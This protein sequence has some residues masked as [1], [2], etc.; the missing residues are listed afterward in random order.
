MKVLVTGRC[1]VF[2]DRMWPSALAAE[3]MTSWAARLGCCATAVHP[4]PA[5]SRLPVSLST[6]RFIEADVLYSDAV[7]PGFVSDVVLVT[8][9]AMVGWASTCARAHSTYCVQRPLEPDP[10]VLAGPRL[11]TRRCTRLVALVLDGPRLWRGLSTPAPSTADRRRP[12]RHE[13]ENLCRRPIRTRVP[14]M[15]RAAAA[16]GWSPRPP[17][18]HPR[19]VYA[20]TQG[21]RNIWP[22]VGPGIRGQCR[23]AV[24]NHKR[25][26]PPD[27]SRHPLRRCRGDLSGRAWPPDNHAPDCVRG[28]DSGGFRPCAGD[29]AAANAARRGVGPGPLCRE[30]SRAFNVASGSLAPSGIGP[31]RWPEAVGRP[32]HRGQPDG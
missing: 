20:A 9:R 2:T 4:Y 5:R 8:S 18:S 6:P 14:R 11:E 21:A 13:H 23:R 28:S 19:N 16:G 10:R 25:L 27:S 12:P 29:V 7:A 32:G 1:R 26:L 30:P 31:P 3:A 24:A 15:R 22:G 17:S